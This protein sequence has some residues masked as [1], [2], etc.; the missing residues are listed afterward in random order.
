MKEK[1]AIIQYS[2]GKDSRAVLEM[3]EPFKDRCIVYFVNTGLMF[4]HMLEHVRETCENLGF[5]YLEIIPPSPVK[6]YIE[7]FGHPSDM[8]STWNSPKI[9]TYLVH[10]PNAKLNDAMECCFRNIM[11]PMQEAVLISGIKTV[12]RGS[13]ITDS[14]VGVPHEFI[15]T[16]GIKYL[17]PL[18]T[19]TDEEVF[20]YLTKHGI[21]LPFHYD[22]VKDSTQCY[23]CTADLHHAGADRLRMTR[24]K[25]PDLWPEVHERMLKV[26][27]EVRYQMSLFNDALEKAGI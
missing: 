18:W 27:Q 12:Y 17:S 15:D 19:W 22:T 23:I 24:E 26:K 25:Y 4:P 20:A 8:L 11:Q 14:K 2:G 13:K 21:E 3:L 6:D 16:N 10:K 1:L 7:E 5:D 9:W